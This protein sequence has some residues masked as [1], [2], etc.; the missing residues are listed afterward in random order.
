MNKIN[1]DKLMQG[2]IDQIIRRGE[3]PLICLH[4]CCAP[5]CSQTLV[6]LSPYFR[7]VIFF[8][9]PNITD[10]PEYYKRFNEVCRLVREMGLAESTEVI[11]GGFD[12]AIFFAQ[13]KGH[14]KDPEGGN[15]CGGC[16]RQRL[17]ATAQK[18]LEI[19]ADYFCSTL[20]VGPLKNAQVI[21]PVGMAEAEKVNIPWLPSDFKKGDGYKKSIELSKQYNLY[22]Q[23]YCGCGF[24]KRDEVAS[25]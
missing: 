20:T 16:F 13:A 24:S 25:G 23:N 5:C 15:R 18:A 14:E 2:E 3:K 4:A 10:E 9:N 21:N 6:R 19:H 7:I 11:D 8:Y 17:E 1:Y 12:P 22:R